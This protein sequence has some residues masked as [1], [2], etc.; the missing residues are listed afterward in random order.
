[1]LNNAG[2]VP[3]LQEIASREALFQIRN[4]QKSQI[5]NAL[6]VF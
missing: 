2:K 3:A 1:L 6:P 4:N 5:K